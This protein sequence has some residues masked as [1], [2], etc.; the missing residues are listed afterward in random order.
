MSW[1]FHILFWPTA[2][3]LSYCITTKYW[4]G[5]ITSSLILI[6]ISV[7]WIYSKKRPTKKERFR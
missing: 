7:L 2:I 6:V 4:F 3:S 5:I 1:I